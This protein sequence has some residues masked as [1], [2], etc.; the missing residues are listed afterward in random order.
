M[1]SNL[2]I[3]ALAAALSTAGMAVPALAHN[4]EDHGA[5]PQSAAG[6]GVIK[7]I[8]VKAGTV[9]IAHGPIPAL[10]WPSMTMKFKVASAAVLNGV[11]VGKKVRFVLKNEHG[12][13]VVSEIEV[14]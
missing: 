5:A 4:G 11:T 6:E 10:K 13:P 12:K 7:A 1:K 2:L 8:D 3:A 14:L 9:V